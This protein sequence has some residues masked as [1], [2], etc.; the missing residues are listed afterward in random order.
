[1]KLARIGYDPVMANSNPHEDRTDTEREGQVSEVG[2][3][4][5]DAPDTPI[6][7]LDQVAASPD[8]EGDLP[9]HGTEVGPDAR[10]GE[11]VVEGTG[12]PPDE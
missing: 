4:D 6:S 7:D 11:D 2:G 8:D 12:E 3:L 10:T 5:P 1:M 9:E